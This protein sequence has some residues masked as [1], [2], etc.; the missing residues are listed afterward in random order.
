MRKRVLIISSYMW[1]FSSSSNVIQSGHS[2]DDN[3]EHAL[4]K[5]HFVSYLW[6]P[7]KHTYNSFVRA[8]QNAQQHTRELQMTIYVAVA[9]DAV[10]ELS[11]RAKEVEE[12]IFFG[13]CKRLFFCWWC[14]FMHLV[15]LKRN[16]SLC[17]FHAFTF[18]SVNEN[19]LVLYLHIWRHWLLFQNWRN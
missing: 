16:F 19:F 10:W 9:T 3:A 1:M 15:T 11:L 17:G 2:S 5:L 8:T 18:W 4:A 14:I 12:K 6:K 7:A 13:A